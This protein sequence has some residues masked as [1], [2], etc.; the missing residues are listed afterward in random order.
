LGES[1]ANLSIGCGSPASRIAGF[2]HKCVQ[3]NS[4]TMAFRCAR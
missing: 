3:I 1:V 4:A 2:E